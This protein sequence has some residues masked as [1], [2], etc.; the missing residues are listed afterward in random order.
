MEIIQEGKIIGAKETLPLSKTELK[1]KSNYI[2]KIVSR[3]KLG[4]GFF[5]NIPY[6]KIFQF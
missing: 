1:Q 5:C 3:N 6:I 4:T 2:C